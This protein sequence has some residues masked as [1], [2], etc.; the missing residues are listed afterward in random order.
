MATSRQ[1]I[2]SAEAL[3]DLETIFL[4]I[5]HDHEA[6]LNAERYATGLQDAAA[7]LGRRTLAGHP[8]TGPLIPPNPY[9]VY[10]YKSHRIIFHPTEEFLKILSIVH[11]RQDFPSLIRGLPFDELAC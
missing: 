5:A 9:R 7:S 11:R 4:R 10:L 2:W 1:V 6:P 3:R 8:L